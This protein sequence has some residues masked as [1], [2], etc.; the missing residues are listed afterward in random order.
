[1][2]VEDCLR[3]YDA[4]DYAENAFNVPVVAYSGSDDPQ[5]A[6]AKNIEDKLKKS[7]IAMTH[8]VAP[9]LKHEFPAEWKKKAEEEY[10][11]HVARGRPEYPSRVRFITYTLKYPSCDWVD[12]LALDR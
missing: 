4:V 3:I 7:G 9:G 8:L 10:A 6:A 1:Y 2:Y 12:I 11:K 5:M